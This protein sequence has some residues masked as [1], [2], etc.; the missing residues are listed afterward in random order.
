MVGPKHIT[1]DHTTLWRTQDTN[2][3]EFRNLEA[4]SEEDFQELTQ[5]I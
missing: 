1:R 2:T 4:A 5:S 3:K